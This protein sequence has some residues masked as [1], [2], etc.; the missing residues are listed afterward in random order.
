M[1]I[2]DSLVTASAAETKR[3]AFQLARELARM[4]SDRARVI[5]LSGNLGAGKTTFTQGFAKALGIAH[6]VQSPTFVLMKIYELEKK[7]LKHLV[8]IDAYRIETAGEL[9]H[10]GFLKLL[11]DG[12]AVILIEWADR[13]KKILPKDTMWLMF[14][15]GK[16]INERIIKISNTIS[17]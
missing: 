11:E 6:P 4:S 17:N 9:E 5:A 13:I 12:D 16:N 1:P 14:E 3:L 2:P 8:H 7:Y 15:H 10:L